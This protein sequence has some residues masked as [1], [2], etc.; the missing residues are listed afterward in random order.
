MYTVKSSSEF[1][2][3]VRALDERLKNIRVN[4]IEIERSACKIRYNFICD[5]AI[6]NELQSKILKEKEKK[7]SI[8]LM[9]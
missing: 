6:D 5:V 9:S 8:Y 4:S 3:D 1:I 2:A 7:Q